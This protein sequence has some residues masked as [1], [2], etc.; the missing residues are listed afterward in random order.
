MQIGDLVRTSN[1]YVRGERCLGLI[2][3]IKVW[4]LGSDRGK[5][6]F[7]V[8]FPDGDTGWWTQDYL[9]IVCK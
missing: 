4:M 3:E 9:E 6:A 1:A 2:V 7:L 8:Q 5:T